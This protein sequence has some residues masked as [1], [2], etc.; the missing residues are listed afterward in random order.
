MATRETADSQLDEENVSVADEQEDPKEALKKVIDVKVTDAGVLRRCVSITVPQDSLRAEFDKDYDELV[1]EAVVPGFRRGR[2]PRRLVEKRFGREVNDQVQTRI[3]SNAYLAAIE[4]EDLKVLGDPLVWVQ[5]KD[6]DKAEE[7]GGEQLLDLQKALQHLSLPD[8]GDFAFRCEVEVKPEFELPKLEEVPIEK[9]SLTIG[10][11]DVQVQIDRIR[12]RRGH[13]VPVEEGSKVEIDDLLVCDMKMTVDGTEV[14]T[15][16]NMQLAARAQM[17][18]GA[19]ISD[20]GDKLKG[21]KAGDK[22]SV[23]AELPDDYDVEGYRGKKATFELLLNEIKRMQLPPLDKDYLSSQGFDSEGEYRSWVKKQMEG[24]LEQ[25]IRRGMREQVREYLLENTKLDLPEG[26]SSRQTERAVERRMV[27]LQMQ[28]VPASEIEKNADE[29]RTGAREQAVAE[30][31]QHFILEEIAEKLDIDVREEEINGRIAEMA[32][33]YNQRFDRVRDQLS[34]N[35]GL[36]SVYLQLRDEKCIDHI[37]EKARITEAKTPKKVA[38]KTKKKTAKAEKPEK[39][40]DAPAETAKKKTAK[41][42]TT[43]KKS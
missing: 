15:V 17:I 21:M 37:L 8:E 27:D 12:A 5:V 36:L 41:K 31:K 20:L 10:D 18:E 26:L 22:A 16:D 42:K 19:V 35:N 4:K 24:Q 7:S 11:D 14:K 38:K 43:K 29:L 23:D 30:L 40:D 3:V 9:P 1:N 33:A 39:S 28:G 34:K 6:K 32:Q 2:A 25:E 13:W